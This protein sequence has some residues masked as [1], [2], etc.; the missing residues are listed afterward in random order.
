MKVLL[1]YLMLSLNGLMLAQGNLHPT[2]ISIGYFGNNGIRPGLKIGT[3]LNLGAWQ[4][5][6]SEKTRINQVFLQPEIGFYTWPGVHTTFITNINFG[7]KKSKGMYQLYSAYSLGVGLINQS[8]IINI[9][10]DLSDGSST[11]VRDNWRWVTST[12]NY[13]F[14]KIYNNNIG[15]YGKLSG[16]YRFASKQPAA[17]IF[18]LEFGLT[19]RFS[20]TKLDKIK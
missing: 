11:N 5:S 13:E 8:Q 18:F 14:G 6:I 20:S 15:W 2:E 12:L 7:F 4:R 9:K 10:V 1:I 19:Y 17:P 3:K 16:G